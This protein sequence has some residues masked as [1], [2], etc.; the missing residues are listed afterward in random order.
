MPKHKKPY[1]IRKRHIVGS[2]AFLM[3]FV[4]GSTSAAENGTEHSEK[5]AVKENENLDQIDE[6]LLEFLGDFEEVDDET[7]EL[8]LF[9][10]LRDS[11]KNNEN[12]E[13]STNE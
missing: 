11:E 12:R 5:P 4:M 3:C 13:G 7:F 6:E 9:H 8:V 10:G 1:A 2:I